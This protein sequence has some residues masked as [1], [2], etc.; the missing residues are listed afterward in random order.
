MKKLPGKKKDGK[1]RTG[2]K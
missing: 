1:N 2:K